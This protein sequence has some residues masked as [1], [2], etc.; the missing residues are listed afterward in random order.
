LP[1]P[2]VLARLGSAELGALL[3]GALFLAIIA[4]FL[5][6]GGPPKKQQ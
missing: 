5:L 6:W 4:F 2:Y 3:G 1:I